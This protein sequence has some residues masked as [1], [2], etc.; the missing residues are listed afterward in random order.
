[1]F[2]TYEILTPEEADNLVD[3]LVQLDEW[4][5]GQAR[6]EALT[7]TVKQ[8]LEI[9]RNHP[10]SLAASD[11][12]CKKLLACDP[13]QKDHLPHKIFSVKFNKYTKTGAYNRHTDSATMHQV[14]TDLACTIFLTDPDSYEGGELCIEQRDGTIFKH[15]GKKGHC[16]VYK[17]GAPHWVTPVTKGSRISGVTWIESYLR[18]EQQRDILSRM[19][20]FLVEVEKDIDHDNPKCKFRTW[21]TNVSSIESNLMRMWIE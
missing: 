10:S 3:Q 6:T 14:R 11:I 8:N 19:R 16:V 13:F 1:M 17:C 15:K 4:K 9:D 21:M 5:Q 7:G 12:L 18:N 2:R 20:R